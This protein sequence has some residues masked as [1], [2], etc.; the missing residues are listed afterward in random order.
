MCIPGSGLWA[1]SKMK[2]IA[3]PVSG[4]GA[5]TAAGKLIN[6]KKSNAPTI[7]KVSPRTN[8]RPAF[9]STTFGAGAPA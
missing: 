4:I 1:A 2:G 7:T 6:P 5:L 3:S 9:F 8:A